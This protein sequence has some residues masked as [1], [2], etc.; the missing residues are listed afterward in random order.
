MARRWI[1]HGNRWQDTAPP[2]F[3]TSTSFF[4][5]WLC[6]QPALA[7]VITT[8]RK[9]NTILAFMELTE[10]DKENKQTKK[11]GQ[12]K[13]DTW[14]VG[15][16]SWGYTGIRHQ[17]RQLKES[18]QTFG[19]LKMFAY[20]AP[21]FDSNK[22]KC[23]TGNK[24]WTTCN[25]QCV[26]SEQNLKKKKSIGFMMGMILQ[27]APARSTSGCCLFALTIFIYD[28]CLLFLPAIEV[29]NHRFSLSNT[30]SNKVWSSSTTL[31]LH[32]DGF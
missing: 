31:S 17:R 12:I 22:Q 26:L 19:T 7:L 32:F 25:N 24:P 9:A 20:L 28:I 6:A 29:Y 3:Y 16:E 8:T 14:K 18:T 21:V 13:M 23:L 27:F 2:L 30:H 15:K 4:E 1:T 11:C 10:R 5:G